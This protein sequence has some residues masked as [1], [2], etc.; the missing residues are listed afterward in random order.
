MGPRPFRFVRRAADKLL[1]HGWA[2]YAPA[3]K[4]WR[5]SPLFGLLLGMTLGTA[6]GTG[7]LAPLPFL[8]VAAATRDRR[9]SWRW[10]WACRCVATFFF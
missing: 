5:W 8:A 7:W 3:R 9:A 10:L 2:A 1:D 6:K 4:D